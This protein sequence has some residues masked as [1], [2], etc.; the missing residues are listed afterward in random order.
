M[1]VTAGRSGS[2]VISAP[3]AARRSSTCFRPTLPSPTATRTGTSTSISSAT[4]TSRLPATECSTRNSRNDSCPEGRSLGHDLADADQHHGRQE[5]QVDIGFDLAVT[6]QQADLADQMLAQGR[7]ARPFDEEPDHAAGLDLEPLDPVVEV[8]RAQRRHRAHDGIDQ[9]QDRE[10][11]AIVV[12]LDVVEA[13]IGQ[14]QEREIRQD[15]I[16]EAE[17][18]HGFPAFAGWIGIL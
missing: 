2:G 17:E 15:T 11:G 12:L 1:T 4:T 13:E 6:A 7:A 16:D 18:S 8:E 9:D 3:P 10:G 5:E 14:R